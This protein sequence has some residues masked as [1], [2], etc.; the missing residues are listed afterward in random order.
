MAKSSSTP[1][2]PGDSKKGAAKKL[3]KISK[4][5]ANSEP[6]LP[7]GKS[8]IEIIKDTDERDI[9]TAAQD[10]N[11]ELASLVGVE[12]PEPSVSEPEITPETALSAAEEEDEIGDL[13]DGTIAPISDELT[14]PL[15]EEEEPAL[16]EPEAEEPADKPE[17]EEVKAPA[18]EVPEDALPDD[19]VTEKAVDAIVA[20]EA[21]KVLAAED[22]AR[23]GDEPRE[24]K[25]QKPA[26]KSSGIFARSSVRWGVF[27]GLL[28]VLLALAAV[29]ASR[30]F[31]LNTAGVRS[32]LEL[33]V[34]DNGTLQPLK[35]VSVQAG[36]ATAL[37][38]SDGV[39]RLTNV[40]LGNTR[41]IIEK[42]AFS[43]IEKSVVVG[44][45][46]NPLGEFKATA[47]GTQY[48]FV[49]KD[50]LSG[51]PI[52]G[53]EASSG[54]GNASSDQEGKIVLTLDTA[55]Q[56]DTAQVN[57]DVWADGYRKETI[58]L[59][60]NN[61]E[62]QSVELV[63]SRKATFISKRSGKYD[64]YTI[65]VDGKNEQKIVS[66]TGLERDDI[67]LIPHQKDEVAALVSTRERV[68]NP[69]GYLLSTL[70]IVNTSNGDLVKI[71]QS[72]KIQVIGWSKA[73]RLV[74]V[75]VAAGSNAT[76]PD[77]HRIMSFNAKDFADTKELAGANAF[78]DVIMAEDRVYYAPANLFQED[79][80][81]GVFA[82]NADGEQAQTVL[83]REAFFLQRSSYDTIDISAGDTW[84]TYKTGSTVSA[85]SSEGPD[86]QVSRIYADNPSNS[87]SLWV[88]KGTLLAYNKQERKDTAIAVKGGLKTPMYWLNER[89]VVFRVRD[90]RETAD[91]VVST[92][93]G[94][95]RKITDVAD[96]S[97]IGRWFD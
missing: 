3:P 31:I 38:D 80:S 29:P 45:G 9:K 81:P 34:T 16:P 88:D 93:G 28:F 36:G 55:N 33:K 72:E 62:E 82:V 96:S 66:G 64:V 95:P 18:E 23:Q 12:V 68:L 76:D 17:A 30:Y 54:D 11:A 32:S 77:R 1:E 94:D 57:V 84:Y 35:N 74:Y 85:Q 6:A 25:L 37:T 49:V 2:T 14:S 70:Y 46:S 10:A 58:N 87:L 48:T 61:K 40:R 90:S 75:K 5:A 41:L 44:W 97:G 53:A 59:T 69:S 56:E 52:D 39:A 67:T 73:G 27:G 20:E 22:Q 50:F 42:R 4:F 51:K 65:D 63:P 78:N 79:Q 24:S 47:V 26:R 86:N 71:D 7:E 21:D 15:E 83:D 19:P 60:V 92:D 43:R 91:Y 8:S 13:N 89:V